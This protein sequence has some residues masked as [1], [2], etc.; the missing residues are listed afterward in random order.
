[1]CGT[2]EGRKRT[3]GLSFFLIFLQEKSK[4]NS[5]TSEEL[6]KERREQKEAQDRVIE[7]QKSQARETGNVKPQR[8]RRETAHAV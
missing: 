3:D 4:K 2:S 1:V 7:G 8:S 6:I 5:K